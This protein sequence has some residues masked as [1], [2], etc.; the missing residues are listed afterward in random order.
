[1]DKGGSNAISLIT[2]TKGA[3]VVSSK[4]SELSAEMVK[5][6]LTV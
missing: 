3:V 4:S 1:V 5:K 6:H 2:L